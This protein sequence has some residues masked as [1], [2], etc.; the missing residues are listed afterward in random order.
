MAGRKS[1]ATY[2]DVYRLYAAQVDSGQLQPGDRLPSSQA[3]E[4][5]HGISHVT[6]AKVY[7]VLQLLGYT[8]ATPR[9]TFVAT[10]PQTRRF[11]RLR[12]S[13]NTLDDTG[14]GLQLE[15]GEN[16]SCIVGRDG[17]VCWSSE[18]ERWETVPT[19]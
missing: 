3:L 16:G 9:G 5:T 18:T 13:L 12:D 14:Q 6:A 19:Q 17:G 11:E 2:K 10:T 7:L 1:T 8:Y 15:V 4:R